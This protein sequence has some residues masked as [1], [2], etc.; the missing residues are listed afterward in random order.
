M[1]DPF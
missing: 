1:Q